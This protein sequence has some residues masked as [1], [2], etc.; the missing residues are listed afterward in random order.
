[1]GLGPSRF[2][3]FTLNQEGHGSPK[4]IDTSVS[5]GLSPRPAIP[6]FGKVAW[7]RHQWAG[8]RALVMGPQLPIARLEPVESPIVSAQR[9][10]YSD[11]QETG[12]GT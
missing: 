4:P 8:F 10:E 11:F 9:R 12:P 1:M 2:E 6:V 3:S 7:G 5:L